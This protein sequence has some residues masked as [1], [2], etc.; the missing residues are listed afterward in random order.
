MKQ[1][2][3]SW[4]RWGSAEEGRSEAAKAGQRA[5]KTRKSPSAGFAGSLEAPSEL[6]AASG[7]EADEVARSGQNS[8]R[9]RDQIESMS[10]EAFAQAGLILRVRLN[11]T[12]REVLFVSDNVPDAALSHRRLPTFRAREL[13]NLATLRPE[14]RNLRSIDE[15]KRLFS[16]DIQDD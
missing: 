5:C 12:G 8:E 13:A 2:V 16:G 11:G 4:S 9:P 6:P 7:E 1:F 15:V 14:P 3:P 10:I